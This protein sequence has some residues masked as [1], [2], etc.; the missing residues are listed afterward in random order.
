MKR[1]IRTS[2]VAGIVALTAAAASAQTVG[3]GTTKGGATAQLTAAIAKIVSQ[4]S[5]MQMRTQ[6]MGGSQQYI[7]VVNAGELEFGIC[8]MPQYYMAKKG[9]GLSRRPYNN[10]ILLA[11]MMKFQVGILVAAKSKITKP[12][13]LKGTRFPTG[14]KASPLIGLILESFLANTGMT[15]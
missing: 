13:D 10:L 8:N 5:P 14:F 9:I 6:P 12:E 2:A 11:N 3:I 7:P 1:F 15:V 4:K